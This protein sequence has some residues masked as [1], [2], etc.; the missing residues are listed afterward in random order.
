[1]I[2]IC[3]YIYPTSSLS[4]LYPFICQGTFDLLP[5]LSYCKQSCYV[6]WGCMYLFELQFSP[7]T[8]PGVGLQDHLVAVF[9]DF[10]RTL[11]SGC[12][13]FHSHQQCGRVPFSPHPLQHLLSVDFLIM[14]I[15]AGGRYYLR[16]ILICISLI[17]SDVEPFFHVSV[18]HLYFFFR[19]TG[20]SWFNARGSCS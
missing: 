3:I 16:V 5:C 18:D 4:I 15:P 17:V 8:C 6:H 19:E 20:P 9:L 12:T 13:I 11:H 1:M 7:D 14:A 10:L 2:Y